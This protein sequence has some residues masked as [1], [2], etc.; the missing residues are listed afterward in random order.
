MRLEI[1]HGIESD[2]LRVR[3][4]ALEN[5]LALSKLLTQCM[6]TTFFEKYFVRSMFSCVRSLTT[7]VRVHTRTA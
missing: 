6:S 2:L 4:K 3:E 5:Y 7:C 1:T